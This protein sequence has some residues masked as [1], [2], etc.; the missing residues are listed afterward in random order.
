M[1]RTTSARR[2]V[3]ART[4]KLRDIMGMANSTASTSDTLADTAHSQIVFENPIR[5]CGHS[6]RALAKL[7]IIGPHTCGRSSVR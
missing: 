6:A 1:L 7:S 2:R 3:V 5:N 4:G